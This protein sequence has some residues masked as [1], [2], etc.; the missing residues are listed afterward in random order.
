MW[1]LH[2]SSQGEVAD[3]T[4]TRIT[5]FMPVV[6]A[7][8][9]GDLPASQR[10]S[11]AAVA[12]FWCLLQDFVGLNLVPPSWMNLP[13]THPFI[14]GNALDG[15]YALVLNPPPGFVLPNTL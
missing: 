1:A 13:H 5:D 11:R 6:S 15:S 10:A 14:G 9:G 7:A 3:P 2:A 12:W 8:H 4:Q